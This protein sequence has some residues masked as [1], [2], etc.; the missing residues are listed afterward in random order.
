MQRRP[1]KSGNSLKRRKDPNQLK[2]PFRAADRKVEILD[3]LGWLERNIH[4][5][6]RRVTEGGPKS[7]W[8]QLDAWDKEKRVLE[9]E[10]RR[11][12][13]QLS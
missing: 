13:R 5:Q 11:I 10:L 8:K 3:R 2:L 12:N 7:I 9:A 6:T 4:E 1:R